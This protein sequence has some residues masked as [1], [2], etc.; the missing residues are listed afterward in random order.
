M[1][2]VYKEIKE[3]VDYRYVGGSWILGVPG[4]VIKAHGN[5]D[6]KAYLGALNQ[7]KLAI[8]SDALAGFT[9][10]LETQ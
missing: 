1:R 4:L 5:S 3:H 6:Q 9:K 7:I 8:E 10:S 2:N